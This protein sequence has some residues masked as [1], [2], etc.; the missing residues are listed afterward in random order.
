MCPALP[1]SPLP[2]A[3]LVLCSSHGARLRDSPS[4]F[5][6]H[7]HY[8]VRAM[9]VSRLR[10]YMLTWFNGLSYTFLPESYVRCGSDD[11][12]YAYGFPS[13]PYNNLLRLYTEAFPYY[14]RF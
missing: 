14:E 13:V 8:A 4:K 3:L 10:F 2:H 12:Q 7:H 6:Y 5:R 11:S 1:G 9:A